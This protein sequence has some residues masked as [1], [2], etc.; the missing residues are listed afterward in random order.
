MLATFR[1]VKIIVTKQVSVK[2][3]GNAN[4]LKDSQVK[5]VQKYFAKDARMVLV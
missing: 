5:I 4:V 1:N 2:K 3:M